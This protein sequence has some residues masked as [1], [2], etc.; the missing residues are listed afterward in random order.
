MDVTRIGLGSSQAAYSA[1][2][3]V[4]S[5]TQSVRAMVVRLEG[6]K[7]RR[8]VADAPGT[9]NAARCAAVVGNG[10]ARTTALYGHALYL[11]AQPGRLRCGGDGGNVRPDERGIGGL[12]GH[13]GGRAGGSRRSP[14]GGICRAA[15]RAGA[16]FLTATAGCAG[17]ETAADQIDPGG[18]GDSGQGTPR[19]S[20]LL[21][22][23][24]AP[25]GRPSPT[26]A[27]GV[28]APRSC[29]HRR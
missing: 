9:V 27:T 6:W 11:S 21:A 26:A 19:R 2:G 12:D 4:T 3:S 1:P 22:Q 28:T 25:L 17:P 15:K 13:G 10:T 20:A 14:Q 24:P 29:Q 8:V 16:A 23:P 7:C 18:R 5:A